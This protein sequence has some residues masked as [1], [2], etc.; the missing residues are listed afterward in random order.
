MALVAG[1][2]MGAFVEEIFGVDNTTEP[3][4]VGL[5]LVGGQLLQRVKNCVFQSVA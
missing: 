5:A 1:V 4:F 2:V 3:R